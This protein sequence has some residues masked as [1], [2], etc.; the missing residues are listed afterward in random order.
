MNKLT[1]LIIEHNTH[2][3]WLIQE[4]L[5]QA[6]SFVAELL[7]AHNLAKAYEILDTQPV[8][9]VVLTLDLPDDS[10]RDAIATLSSYAPNMP[11]VLLADI[12]EA[13]ERLETLRNTGRVYLAKSHMAWAALEH[14]IVESVEEN[15]IWQRLQDARAASQQQEFSLL[16]KLFQNRETSKSST[17]LSIRP[18]REASAQLF[19]QKVTHYQHLLELTLEQRAYKID[20]E[21]TSQLRE[22]AQQ[23]A[24]LKIGPRDLLD[25][26]KVAL[27]R[28]VQGQAA[29]KAQVYLE[30]ARLMTLELMGYLVAHYRLYTLAF[31]ASPEGT[32]SQDQ[33]VTALPQDSEGNS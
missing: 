26:H 30:E 31:R 5:S 10:G 18:L 13:D 27:H 12:T 6:T 3:V 21:T 1:I 8:D 15:L 9:V 28:Q 16:E 22:F 4:V 19:E 11:V 2:D 20:H 32:A 25:I 24:L 14:K 17:S 29:K 33:A 7:V 23:L